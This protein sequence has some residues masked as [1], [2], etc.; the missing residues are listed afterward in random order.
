VGISRNARRR[1]SG[2]QNAT[3]FPLKLRD[4]RDVPDDLAIDIEARAHLLLINS[5]AAHRGEWFATPWE[6]AARAITN[7]EKQVGTLF[8]TCAESL[9]S[10]DAP[11]S[12]EKH[13]NI[14]EVGGG[15]R[16]RTC[17]GA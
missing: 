10:I 15:D 3:P 16:I 11:D 2:L 13:S 9:S 8:G 1:L 12:A 4:V 5:G 7:A 14:K 6:V 17:E